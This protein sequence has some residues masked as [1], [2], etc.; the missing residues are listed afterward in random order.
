MNSDL[1]FEIRHTWFSDQCASQRRNCSPS[2]PRQQEGAAKSVS[3]MEHFCKLNYNNNNKNLRFALE[4]YVFVR[5]STRFWHFRQNSMLFNNSYLMRFVFF[6]EGAAN[7]KAGGS[8]VS[9]LVQVRAIKLYLHAKVHVMISAEHRQGMVL[10]GIKCLK[11]GI[12]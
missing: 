5:F 2:K 6:S 11:L 12:S 1:S 4:M 10:E 8:N 3:N 7:G 9:P